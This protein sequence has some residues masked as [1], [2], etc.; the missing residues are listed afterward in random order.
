VAAHVRFELATGGVDHEGG[1][2]KLRRA[3]LDYPVEAKVLESAVFS[4]G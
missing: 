2:R 4:A 3:V 1:V